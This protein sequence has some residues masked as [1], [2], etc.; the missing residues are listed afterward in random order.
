M[1]KIANEINWWINL[2]AELA[3]FVVIGIAGYTGQEIPVDIMLVI[4]FFYLVTMR[5]RDGRIGVS[6]EQRK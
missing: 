6:N 1:R 5:Y 2:L 3:G 4:V